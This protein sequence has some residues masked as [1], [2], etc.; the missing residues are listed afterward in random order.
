[1]VNIAAAIHKVVVVVGVSVITV[2]HHG[3][4]YDTG[5][6]ATDNYIRTYNP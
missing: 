6:K 2:V 5:C 3:S 1:M 4:S